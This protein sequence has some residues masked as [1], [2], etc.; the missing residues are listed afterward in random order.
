MNLQI[1]TAIARKD[2]R[3]VQQNKTA[4]M[5]MVIVPVMF[6][7]L[8]PLAF[9]LIPPSVSSMQSSFSDP[10]D[11]AAFMNN[12]PPSFAQ[13]IQGLEAFPAMVKIILGYFFAPFFLMFPLMFATII[14]AESFAGERER[15]TMEALLYTP[16]SDAEL[17]LGKVLAAFVPAVL[18]TWGSFGLYTLVVNAAGWS[19]FQGLWFPLLNWYPLIFW[20]TPALAVLGIAFTVLISARTATFMGAYQSSAALVI[21]VLGLVVGQATGVLY[22]SVGVGLALGL[23][24]WAVDAALVWVA[25]R[26]FNRKQLLISA[27]R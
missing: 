6:V 23:V 7:V 11:M 13:S 12:M 1:I 16:A 20:I 3:E 25:I 24:V 19:L 18:I 15:K 9:I 17:F 14:A 4:W 8:L 5:P 27:A 22:L 2:L 21:L 10:A 26:S